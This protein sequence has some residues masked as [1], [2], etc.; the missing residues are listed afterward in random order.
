M[1]S[2]K[3][4]ERIKWNKKMFQ[5]TYAFNDKITYRFDEIID[6]NKGGTYTTKDILAIYNIIDEK[7][8]KKLQDYNKK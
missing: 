7:S 4:K 6:L 3:R 5:G 8:Q 2:N 1:V